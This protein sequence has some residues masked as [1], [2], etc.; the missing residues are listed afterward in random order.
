VTEHHGQPR[1][2]HTQLNLNTEA[3]IERVRGL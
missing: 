3:V 1:E 2:Q